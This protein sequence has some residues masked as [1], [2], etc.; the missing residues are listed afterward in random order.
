M[1]L[2][3]LLISSVIIGLTSCSD[4]PEVNQNKLVNRSGK[5]YLKTSSDPFTGVGI[6]YYGSGEKKYESQY[7]NGL[8]HGNNYT[9]YL[10]GGKKMK[11]VYDNGYLLYA[12]FWYPT[13]ER[14]VYQKYAGGNK[15]TGIHEEWWPNGQRRQISSFE[16]GQIVSGSETRWDESGNEIK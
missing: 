1:I 13:G 7:K 2:R 3:Y 14:S 4:G 6:V 12:T 15:N 5:F 11:Q 16:N 9:Y 10:N 8:S